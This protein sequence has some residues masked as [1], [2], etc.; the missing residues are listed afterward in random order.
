[1]FFNQNVFILNHPLSITLVLLHFYLDA[2]KTFCQMKKELGEFDRTGSK[3][4]NQWKTEEKDKEKRAEEEEG[5]KKGEI[6][7]IREKDKGANVIWTQINSRF[8][9]VV[10]CRG[11]GV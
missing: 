11:C 9:G 4:D 7:K 1:M 2:A 8:H 5:E 6:G 3:E 10:V